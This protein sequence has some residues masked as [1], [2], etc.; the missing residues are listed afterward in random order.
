[1][2][3]AFIVKFCLPICWDE[4][5]SV[6]NF[7]QVQTL[8]PSDRLAV[9]SGAPRLENNSASECPTHEFATRSAYGVVEQAERLNK[10]AMN[11]LRILDFL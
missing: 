7:F 9:E 3:F 10:P 2:P 11:R 8:P 5:W 6:H 4:Y 1:M